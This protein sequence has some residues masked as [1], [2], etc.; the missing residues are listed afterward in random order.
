MIWYKTAGVF[1]YFL[2]WW[3][4]CCF[5]PLALWCVL[6]CTFLWLRPG[7]DVCPLSEM[8]WSS[9]LEHAGPVRRLMLSPLK[10]GW[11]PQGG[12]RLTCRPIRKRYLLILE[13]AIYKLICWPVFSFYL[14]Q[15]LQSFWGRKTHHHLW[16][17]SA[18]ISLIFSDV[19][20]W[21]V[22]WSEWCGSSQRHD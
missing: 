7:L 17:I 2:S 12:Q 19:F 6:F 14:S 10:S 8:G 9:V 5:Q 13:F 22:S 4:F 3:N 20:H 1:K 21:P 11:C 18:V 16:F 15:Y